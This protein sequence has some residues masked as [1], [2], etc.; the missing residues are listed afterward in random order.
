MN[1]TLIS[2]ESDSKNK[3]SY[4]LIDKKSLV[5]NIIDFFI[6][7]VLMTTCMRFAPPSCLRE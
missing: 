1:L 2:L 5:D 6:K 4:Y 7:I 3:F